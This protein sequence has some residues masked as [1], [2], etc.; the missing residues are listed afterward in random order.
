M[1]DT[2][3]LGAGLAA[4]AVL[5]TLGATVLAGARAPGEGSTLSRGAAGWLVARRYLEEKGTEVR[6]IDRDPATGD[7]GAG[8]LALVFPWQVGLGGARAVERHL[9]GGGDVLFAYSGRTP[10]W[11]ET[12]T[13]AALGLEWVDAREAPPLHPVRWRAY[14][15][16]EWMLVDPSASPAAPPVRIGA[17][18][19]VPRAP[20][21]ATVWLQR[22]DGRALAFSYPRERGRVLAVPAEAL[23]NARIREHGNADLLERLRR[24]RPGPWTFDEYHHG[25]VAPAAAGG[26]S[27][28]RTLNLYLVQIAFLYLLAALAVAR[29]FGPAW[30]EGAAA[31]G[32]VASFL[33]GLGALHDRLGHHA[34]AAA[35]LR[36]RAREL[37]GRLVLPARP[38]ASAAELLDLAREVGAAQSGRRP[39]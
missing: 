16:E 33:L 34:Q 20:A 39:A 5:A 13:A 21:R 31:S 26:A 32:S 10:S 23:A 2:T 22:P 28:S 6:L 24:E 38:V 11:G 12:E 8:V 7:T 27:G 36:A 30:R 19:M 25:L 1:R 3:R 15:R 29:R 4:L 9:R 14:A 35:L 17:P 37:D 18:R